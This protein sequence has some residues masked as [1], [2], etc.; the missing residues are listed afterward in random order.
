MNK[1]RA[2]TVCGVDRVNENAREAPPDRRNSSDV[3]IPVMTELH[4]HLLH[5]RAGD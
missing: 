1:M 5:A 2:T 4:D 3:V